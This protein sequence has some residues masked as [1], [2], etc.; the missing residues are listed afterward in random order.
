MSTDAFGNDFLRRQKDYFSRKHSRFSEKISRHQKIINDQKTLEKRFP[1]LGSFLKRAEFFFQTIVR[2][3]LVAICAYNT[4]LV[5]PTAKP[6]HTKYA[7]MATK[8]GPF[9]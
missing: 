8:P 5:T 7:H 3:G 1:T 4:L 6:H 9:L 2:R